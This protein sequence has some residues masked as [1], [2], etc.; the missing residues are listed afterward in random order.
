[1]SDATTVFFEAASVLVAQYLQ[2]LRQDDP[3]GYQRL[4]VAAAG[5]AI[6]RLQTNFGVA[7]VLDCRLLVIDSD[8]SVVE[9]GALEVSNGGTNGH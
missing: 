9:I 3:A 5:G 8:G 1:M 2:G 4:N 7:G 6:F